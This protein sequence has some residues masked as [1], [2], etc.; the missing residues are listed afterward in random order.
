VVIYALKWKQT[1]RISTVEAY[2]TREQA[3]ENADMNN[4][5]IKVSRLQR[6]L[7]R[8]WKVVTINVKEGK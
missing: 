3:Q 6:I 1:G 5:D 8:Y 7:G 4:K 2:L